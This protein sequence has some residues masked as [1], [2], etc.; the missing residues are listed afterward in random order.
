VRILTKTF[1]VAGFVL[2]VAG[3]GGVIFI[4]SQGIREDAAYL[5]SAQY[6]RCHVEE[7]TEWHASL[8]RKMMRRVDEP[9][10]VVADLDI[11]SGVPFDPEAAVWVIGSKWEQQFMGERDG[12]E[13]L[14]PGAWLVASGKWKRKGW[15]G[16]Q[17]PVPLRRCHGCHTVG[18]DLESGE[19]VEPGIGCES[20]HGPGSWHVETFGLG[21]I[22]SGADAQVCGQCHTRGRSPDGQYFFPA[23][24]RPGQRLDDHFKELGPYGDQNS[25]QWWGNGHAR[26]RHE[27]YF[28]WRQGGGARRQ[29]AQ[30]HRGL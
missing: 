30:S 14:L 29:P 28:A 12:Q 20:C 1:L 15:D 9:G 21:R 8:H 13:V 7:Y 27:E 17:V 3:I 23:H 5:G 16:W 10:A 4:K 19:F 11:G 22:Y 18:L 24:Y 26:K 6:R 25:S 2:F